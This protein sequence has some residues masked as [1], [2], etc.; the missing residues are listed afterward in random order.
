MLRLKASDRNFD[1]EFSA[2]VDRRRE[3]E[4]DV[5]SAVAGILTDVRQRGDEALVELTRRLDRAPV[6]KAD[7]LCV[8]ESVIETARDS[9]SPDVLDAMKLAASRIRDFHER[10]RPEGFEH[11]DDAGIRLGQRWTP[12][13]AAGIYV[14]GG[15]AAYPSSVLMNAIPAIVAG[16]SRLVMTV[17]AP[18]GILNPMVLAAAHLVG[19]RE[20]Y[21]IG[22]AQAVAA[23][24]Y[25]TDTIP[26]V[27]KIVGPGNEWVAE[28]KRQVFGT[29]GIDMIAGPSEILVVADNQNSPDWIA[30][31]LLS[32]AEHDATAQSILI[33]NDHDFA[34]AVVASL[35]SLLSD[36]PRSDIATAS[37][38]NHGA[39]I[40]VE[41]L[42]DAVALI[43]QV[44]PEHLQLAI[45][46]PES[47]AGKVANAGAIFLGRYTPEAVG[48]YVAGPNHVLPTARTSR[49]ASGLSVTDFLKRTT[50]IG[51]DP[52]SLQ[53][54]GPAAVTLAGAEGLH[55]HALS[56]SLR[57]RGRSA[58]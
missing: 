26:P 33:A 21:C 35:E 24:S 29:V 52:D 1:S 4:R 53:R 9:C 38:N 56:V 11:M 3:A 41:S 31:D 8:S 30:A 43:D 47:L 40:V 44:A 6:E 34:D 19:I 58:G 37:W 17:P 45:A 20:I 13:A 54:I 2:F 39:V 12:V 57:L 14:P 46:D 18:Q 7:D 10:Q 36:M 42:D 23:L 22:G 5:A 25:G 27:D 55:A 48:D 51:C 49:F 28:A 50:F 16:V 32:Q 15:Q